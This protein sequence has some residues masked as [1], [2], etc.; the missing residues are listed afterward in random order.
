MLEKQVE[1]SKVKDSQNGFF[2]KGF[3]Y[4]TILSFVVCFVSVA[5][6]LNLTRDK[7]ESTNGSYL[8]YGSGTEGNE[9]VKGYNKGY[10]D[11][12]R[13]FRKT[14]VYWTDDGCINLKYK[15]WKFVERDDENV[16]YFN[17]I[18][19]SDVMSQGDDKGLTFVSGKPPIRY[20]VYPKSSIF[21]Q[22]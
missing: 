11:G 5:I 18:N 12:K 4:G 16:F 2:K 15:T 17:Y 13:V 20:K 14:K 8:S 21:M 19:C 10:K 3:L 7:N 1:N 6:Y 22:E 9:W